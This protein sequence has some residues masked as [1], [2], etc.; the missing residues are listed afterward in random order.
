MPPA[1]S[2]AD[3][4]TAM[5]VRATAFTTIRVGTAYPQGAWTLRRRPTLG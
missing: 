5:R 4:I 2:S 3:A 1:S